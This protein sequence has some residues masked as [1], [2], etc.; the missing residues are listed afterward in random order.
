[1]KTYIA[2]KHIALPVTDI[3][4]RSE[5]RCMHPEVYLAL[6]AINIITIKQLRIISL[7]LSQTHSSP[8][9]T[10]PH[11]FCIVNVVDYAFWQPFPSPMKVRFYTLIM[12]I[13][14]IVWE[15]V[16]PNILCC[17]HSCIYPGKWPF[18][19]TKIRMLISTSHA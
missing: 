5:K 16:S 6:A 8:L 19:S 17:L 10:F 11:L 18:V 15:I 2:K 14:N 13:V 3:R 4:L 7:I 12:I 9:R 1:M